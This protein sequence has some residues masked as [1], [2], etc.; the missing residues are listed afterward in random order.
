[1][2]RPTGRI[3]VDTNNGKYD[4][5]R[6][7]FESI[8]PN[9]VD[10]F[11]QINNY[12][13]DNM[14]ELKRA[15]GDWYINYYY[16]KY[17]KK[18]VVFKVDSK[19]DGCNI[20]CLHIALYYKDVENY[21]SDQEVIDFNISEKPDGSHEH[22]KLPYQATFTDKSELKMAYLLLEKIFSIAKSQLEKY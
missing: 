9:A 18:Y 19:Q 8:A 1:M 4:K 5:L 14:P 17:G 3:Q 10:L 2:P 20:D 7:K 6:A 13:K 21:L 16:P 22:G 12:V 15:T 11:D